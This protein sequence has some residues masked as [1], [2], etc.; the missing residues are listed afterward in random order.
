[1]SSNPV[2]R[3][4]LIHP[5]FDGIPRNSG[6]PGW[7]KTLACSC[8]QT[9]PAETRKRKKLETY[10]ECMGWMWNYRKI[11]T[12]NLGMWPCLVKGPS[13]TQLS[14]A[15]WDEIIVAYLARAQS[16]T[17]SVLKDKDKRQTWENCPE[18]KRAG[19]IHTLRSTHP[20]QGERPETIYLLSLPK[21]PT[22]PTSYL[23][24]SISAELQKSLRPLF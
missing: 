2:G 16:Q 4:G 1:M 23:Q 24:T 19:C 10:A 18:R 12:H 13:Q 15:L 3:T 9:H 21:E 7:E 6:L 17:V 5:S 14:Y 8:R 11:D 22:L 20:K